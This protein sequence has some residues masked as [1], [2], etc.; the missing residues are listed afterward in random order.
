MYTRQFATWKVLDDISAAVGLISA[1]LTAVPT[2]R[3][4]FSFGLSEKANRKALSFKAHARF[5]TG[6][7]VSEV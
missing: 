4:R 2:S 5:Y 6:R 3:P 7:K 1:Y